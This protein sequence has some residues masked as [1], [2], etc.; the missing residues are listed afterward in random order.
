MHIAN[1]AECAGLMRNIVTNL[2]SA[3]YIKSYEIKIAFIQKGSESPF[4]IVMCKLA[5]ALIVYK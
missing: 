5:S 2:G 4:R 3:C 1:A